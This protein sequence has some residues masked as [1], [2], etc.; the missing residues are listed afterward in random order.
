MFSFDPV[1]PELLLELDQSISMNA[2]KL[3]IDE[4]R[5]KGQICKELLLNVDEEQ[6]EDNVKSLPSTI[7][8]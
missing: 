2:S 8:V 3:W 4:N 6:S 1:D 7:Q 5:L